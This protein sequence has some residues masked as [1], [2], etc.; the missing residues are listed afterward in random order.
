MMTSR[1]LAIAALAVVLAAHPLHGQDRARYRGYVLGGDLALISSLSGVAP[2]QVKAI[3]LRPALIQQLEWQ[4]PY[5]LNGAAPVDVVKQIIFSFYNDQL[6]KMMID[7]DADRTAGM[8]DEDLVEAISTEYGATVKSPVR[9]RRAVAAGEEDESGAPVAH[10]GDADY[11]VVLYRAIYTSGFR[12]VVASPRLD[13]LARAATVQATRLD[14]LNAPKV[15]AARL[16]K[17]AADARASQ[18]K[19]RTVNKAAFRP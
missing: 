7:Y 9:A 1:S 13:A 14:D 5:A 19:M 17:E 16:K 10:W 11:S 8:T 3:H 2:A 15:E 12:V 6:F 18:A 4:R